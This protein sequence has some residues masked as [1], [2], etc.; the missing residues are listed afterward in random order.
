MALE[1]VHAI[2]PAKIN[3]AL[4]VGGPRADGFHPLDTVFEAI[5]L[6]DDVI[7]TPGKAPGA[8]TLEI[9]GLGEDL[10]TD[11]S[12]LA[13]KAGRILQD[14]FDA[15]DRSAHISITKKIPVAGGMA[16]GSADAAGTLVALNELWELGASKEV[17]LSLAGE[18]GSDVPFALIGS[19]AHGTQRGEV[20]EPIV[21]GT[22]HG[23]VIATNPR[24]LSTPAVFAEFDRL[25]PNADQPASTRK[26]REAVEGVDLAQLGTLLAND[27]EIPAFSLRPDLADV[28]RRSDEAGHGVVL[29]GSGPSIAV[30]CDVSD[31]AELARDAQRAF[32]DLHIVTA[33][34]PA[35]GAHV[36]KS[37]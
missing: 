10:P 6:F 37:Y 27:L 15:R 20:L 30:L 11:E 7:A 18:L 16:G 14:R 2:A 3:L 13:I 21:P 17:L 12:N 1:Y 31:G 22:M 19:V 23:F 33:Y 25:F 36:V 34:G 9:H 29:C 24:G 4:H 32:P 5:D 35:A 28:F 26:V 8:L